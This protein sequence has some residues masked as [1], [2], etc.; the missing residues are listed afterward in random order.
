MNPRIARGNT[1]AGKW[2]DYL[3]PIRYD[4]DCKARIYD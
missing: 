2:E 1:I 3:K 4:E